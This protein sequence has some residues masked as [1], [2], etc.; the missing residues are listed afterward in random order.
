MIA[1]TQQGIARKQRPP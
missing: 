1:H